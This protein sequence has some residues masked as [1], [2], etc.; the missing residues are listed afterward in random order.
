MLVSYR[1][2][3]QADRQ[4]AKDLKSRVVEAEQIANPQRIKK[5]DCTVIKRSACMVTSAPPSIRGK[6]AEFCH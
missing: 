6:T 1:K 3:N 2:L 4:R 5:L